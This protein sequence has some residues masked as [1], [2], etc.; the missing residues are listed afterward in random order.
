MFQEAQAGY[1]LNQF[2][3]LTQTGIYQN[4]LELS[5]ANHNKT[6]TSLTFTQRLRQE[7]QPLQPFWQ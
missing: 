5:V 1:S 3:G 2:D 7:T 4:E 6:I